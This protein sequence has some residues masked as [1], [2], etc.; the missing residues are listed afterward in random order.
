MQDAAGPMGRATT[1]RKIGI[2]TFALVAAVCISPAMR[3]DV[4]RGGENMTCE[5]GNPVTSVKTC[6]SAVNYYGSV[7]AMLLIRLDRD[8]GSEK[9]AGFRATRLEFEKKFSDADALELTL[10]RASPNASMRGPD[11]NITC[12]AHNAASTVDTCRSAVRHYGEE[13]ARLL[14]RL[15]RDPTL[16][17]DLSFRAKRLVA[18]QKYKESRALLWA[19]ANANEIKAIT[20][21]KVPQ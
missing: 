11:G 19:L 2:L 15:D 21:Q 1:Y 20:A 18:E 12:D 13:L 9:D 8:V 16:Q 7:L 14:I 4:M 6:R 5:I 17:S 3:A 10:N